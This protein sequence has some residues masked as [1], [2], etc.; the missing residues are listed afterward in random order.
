MHENINLEILVH[1]SFV[2]YFALLYGNTKNIE[3]SK[4]K[5]DTRAH[6][7]CNRKDQEN[8]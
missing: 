2:Y 1:Y 8:N 6:R 4:H 3:K 5:T 7:T